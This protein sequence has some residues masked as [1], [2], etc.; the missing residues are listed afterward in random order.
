SFALFVPGSASLDVRRIN[1]TTVFVGNTAGVIKAKDTRM[2][3]MNNDAKADL[4]VFFDATHAQK[5]AAL[6]GVDASL[7]AK[8]IHDGPVGMHFTLDD[9]T[10][11]LVRNIYALG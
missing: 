1:T 8:T 11:Y 9:G 7:D 6:D 5:G 3:D 10:G 2:V 4:A